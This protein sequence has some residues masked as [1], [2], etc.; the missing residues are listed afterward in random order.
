MAQVI[1]ATWRAQAGAEAR[2]VRILEEMARLS[3]QEPGCLLYQPHRSVDDAR[4]FFLYEQY[5][6]DGA[7]QAHSTSEY[8]HRLVLG[9]ALPLL[10]SRDR[11]IYQTLDL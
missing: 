8:F 5:V 2:I 1:A 6:D 10:E 4:V 3:R 7:L 9:E 11:Q